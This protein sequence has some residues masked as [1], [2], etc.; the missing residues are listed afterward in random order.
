VFGIDTN[1]TLRLSGVRVSNGRA[2]DVGG[3]GILIIG[4]Q[5]HLNNTIVSFNVASLSSGLQVIGAGIYNFTGI[6]EVQNSTVSNNTNSS[7]GPADGGGIGVLGGTTTITRTTIN[8]NSTLRDGGGLGIVQSTAIV[9]VQNSKF[10]SNQAYSGGGVFSYGRDVQITK[11]LVEFNA[12]GTAQLGGGI[13]GYTNL[14]FPSISDSCIINNSDISAAAFV[15]STLMAQR[16]WWGD[17]NGPVVNASS[18]GVRD[19]VNSQV[20]YSSFVTVPPSNTATQCVEGVYFPTPTPSPTPTLTPTPGACNV[21]TNDVS[22]ITQTVRFRI[23]PSLDIENWLFEIPTGTLPRAATSIQNKSWLWPGGSVPSLFTVNAIDLIA[24]VGVIGWVDPDIQ[25]YQVRIFGD[26]GGTPTILT[27]YMQSTNTAGG[28]MLNIVC[29]G[30]TT[31]PAPAPDPGMPS[32]GLNL[33]ADRPPQAR[34]FN[35]NQ[36]PSTMGTCGIHV[37][38][39][40]PC[41]P[42]PSGSTIDVVPRNT[43]LCIDSR[44]SN[45][46]IEC[47]PGWS[48]PSDPNLNPSPSRIPVYAPRDGCAIFYD[49][50]PTDQPP[51]IIIRIDRYNTQADCNTDAQANDRFIVLTHIIPE[52]IT[53]ANRLKISAG[54]LVGYIC[55]SNEARSICQVFDDNTPTH[56]AFLVVIWNGSQYVQAP[57]DILGYLARQGCLY[58]D[59]ASRNSTGTPQIQP[60]PVRACP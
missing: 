32:A 19:S 42:D 13:Y 36:S 40:L 20:N 17:V 53:A 43:E 31:L 4:G 8:N 60:S 5:A 10:Q 25:W 12:V 59:W 21:M 22:S 34:L 58:D 3:S 14:N 2:T 54:T 52:G 1:G 50:P 9:R 30:A 37:G 18:P 33:F 48:N 28:L 27:G 56:L 57:N 16:N 29:T 46:L 47:N 15:G 26:A 55:L 24:R 49:P 38:V 23:Q 35:A 44:T 39:S 6:L 45:R 7:T 41:S 51:S 11:S